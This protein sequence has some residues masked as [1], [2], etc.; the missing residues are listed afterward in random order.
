VDVE[1]TELPAALVAFTVKVYDVEAVNP[2]ITI[3]EVV[4]V[5][6]IAPGAEV[7]I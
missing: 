1:A 7:T 3:G 6:V 4:P 2:V 5:F